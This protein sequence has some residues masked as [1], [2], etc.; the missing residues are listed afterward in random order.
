MDNWPDVELRQLHALRAIAA[1]GTF[2]A[3]A[4]QLDVAQ[5]TISDQVAGL[6]ELTGQRLIERSRGRRTVKL[7]AAG[8]LLL[9]HV[10][11][12]EARL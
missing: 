12:I 3:A 7:T 4:E 5:S 2:W 6:E 9:G 1:T 8:R 11:A 10:T